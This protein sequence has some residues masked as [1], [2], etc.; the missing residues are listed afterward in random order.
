M[1]G[2]KGLKKDFFPRKE[3]TSHSQEIKRTGN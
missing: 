3:L 2:G 1:P